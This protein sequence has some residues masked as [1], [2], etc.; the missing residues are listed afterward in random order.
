[1]FDYQCNPG[2]VCL[3]FY[4]FFVIEIKTFWFIIVSEI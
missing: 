2:F 3:F 1:M 4:I